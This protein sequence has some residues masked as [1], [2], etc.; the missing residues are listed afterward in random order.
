MLWLT[1]LVL[2][3]SA[4]RAVLA[5]PQPVVSVPELTNT[6]GIVDLEQRAAPTVKLDSATVT[7]VSS[8]RTHKFLGIPFAKPPVGDLRFRQPQPLGAYA[9]SFEATEFGLSCPQQAISLPLGGGLVQEAVDYITN[10]IFGAVFPDSEDCLTI[11]VVKP[12]SATPDSKLPVAVWI[13]GGGFELG[14]TT[15][16]DGATIVGKSI[17]IGKPVIYVS[18]NYRVTGFGFMA[19]KEIKDAGVGNLGLQDQRL[20]L[21]WIQKYISS[22]GGDP[23]K[24][25]IWGESAG[26]ISVAL[27]MV[28]NGG[29]NEGLFR[30]AFMESGSPIPVGDISHGQKYYDAVVK[31]TGCATSSDTLA[32]LR[33]VDYKKLKSAINKTP[34]IFSYQSLV[35]SYLPRVDGVFLTDNPQK[36]AEKGE[37]AQVPFV[38]GDCDD[39]GTLFSLS[40][41]NITTDT[42]LRNYIRDYWLPEAPS[43]DIDQLM[44]L[45]PGDITEGSPYDTGVFNALSPQSKRIAS[46]QGDVVFQG[47][48]RHFLK[49]TSSKQNTWSFLSKRLKGVPVLG[50]FHASDIL[51]IYGGGD[52]TT[53]FVQFVNNLDP[54]GNGLTNWPKYTTSAPNLLTFYDGLIP[55]GVERDDYRKDAIS[56]LTNV[57]LAHPL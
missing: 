25:T 11:N 48:R 50:S 30:G 37:V 36:L 49:H 32:C 23:T 55:R 24:V 34:G 6:T 3:A 51:N 41:L 14:G 2:V 53:Y 47:P 39:E 38:T 52:M 40:T 29:N 20:A 13:F 56:Y 12:A 42:Q 46:F 7:G 4:S 43:S 57:A 10:T 18:M 45:Y 27:H 28:T 21:R 26:A 1:S 22:F 9:G 54:N 16:Y 44:K 31:D 17:D 15:M 8:L 19:S 35:L 33:K 5:S